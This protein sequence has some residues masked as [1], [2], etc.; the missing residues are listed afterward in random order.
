MAQSRAHEGIAAD[1]RKLIGSMRR[2]R[3]EDPR[4]V[5]L[6]GS[7][8]PPCASGADGLG[9]RS[10]QRVQGSHHLRAGA[11]V[12]GAQTSVIALD[13]SHMVEVITLTHQKGSREKC[14]SR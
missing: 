8:S 7:H 5:G 14:R 13:P 1:C 12:P 11:E 2:T 4:T 9:G 3:L 6:T 10:G